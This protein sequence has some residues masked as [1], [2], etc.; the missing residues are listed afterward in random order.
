MTKR[1]K[2]LIG[3]KELTKAI[4][5]RIWKDLSKGYIMTE[6]IKRNNVSHQ[7][8]DFVVNERMRINRHEK[9]I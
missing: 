5:D 7:T 9:N 1:R 4:K 2:G 8:I 3:I 6:I